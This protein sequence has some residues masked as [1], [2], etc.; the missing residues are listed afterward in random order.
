[1]PVQLRAGPPG[2]FE[3]TGSRVAP[4]FGDLATLLPNGRVLASGEVYDQASGTWTTT[5]NSGTS[6][7]TLLPNGKV[8]TEGGSYFNGHLT[9]ARPNAAIYNPASGTWAATASMSTARYDHATT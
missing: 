9:R 4:S 7:P 5:E 3:A 1:M 2:F 8:L 6:A